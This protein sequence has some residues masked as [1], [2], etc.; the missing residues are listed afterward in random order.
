VRSIF[1]VAA[2]GMV[3]LSVAGCA[4]AN[5]AAQH[6][7]GRKTGTTVGA[8]LPRAATFVLAAGRSSGQHQITAPSPAT[9]EFDVSIS[10]PTSANVSLSALT[11]NGATLSLITSTRDHQDYLCRHQGSRDVCLGRFPLLP[12]QQGGTWTLLASKRSDPGATVRVVI[13]FAKP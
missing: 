9:Y 4:G 8:P 12:A 2:C 5:T 11:P 6:T 10:V 1:P 3:A 7:G 13:T